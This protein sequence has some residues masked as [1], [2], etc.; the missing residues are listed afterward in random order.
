M[1]NLPLGVNCAD[2]SWQVSGQ[3]KSFKAPIFKEKKRLFVEILFS[4]YIIFYLIWFNLIS[5]FQYMYKFRFNRTVRCNPFDSTLL[6]DDIDGTF[7]DYSL[8]TL[9]QLF[10][11]DSYIINWQFTSYEYIWP[12]IAIAFILEKQGGKTHLTTLFTNRTQ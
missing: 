9:I 3:F 2:N 6:H 5:L 7:D 12:I 1:T 10:S 4:N 8:I 11:V